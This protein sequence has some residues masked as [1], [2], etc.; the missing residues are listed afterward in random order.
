MKAIKV[1]KTW[2][3]N[4]RGAWHW[5]VHNRVPW[6]HLGKRETAVRIESESEWLINEQRKTGPFFC[7]PINGTSEHLTSISADLRAAPCEVN[8]F[9]YSNA[10]IFFSV[11]HL[12][13][14]ISY[15]LIND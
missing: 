2:R 7:I 6:A 12:N 13:W 9:Y 11:K 14:S 4:R 8:E 10:V 15:K 1:D 5:V 3:E